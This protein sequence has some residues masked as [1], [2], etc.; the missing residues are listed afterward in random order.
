LS[1]ALTGKIRAKPIEAV[2]GYSI[3]DLRVHL[4]R[5]FA[6]GMSWETYAGNNR[7]GAPGTWVIDHIVPKRCFIERQIRDAFAISNLRP[8]CSKKNIRK[9]MQRTHLI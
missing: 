9:N 7:F 6:S 8:L 3:A 5:Q 2:L 1:W 4:E